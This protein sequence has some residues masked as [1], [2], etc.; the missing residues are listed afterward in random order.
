MKEHK[1]L[2]DYVKIAEG[3]AC[4]AERVYSYRELDK[5][6]KNAAASKGP[7]VIDIICDDNTDCDM[8]PDIAHIRHFD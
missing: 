4:K 5:A 7:Y 8:G 6:L 2:M 3:F 1:P